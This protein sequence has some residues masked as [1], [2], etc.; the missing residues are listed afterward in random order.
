MKRIQ[1]YFVLIC[2]AALAS[3]VKTEVCVQPEE[4]AV[5]ILFSADAGQVQESGLNA[6]SKSIV[7]TP[8]GLNQPG[9]KLR[10]YDKHS[11][12]AN[13][14]MYIDGLDYVYGNSGWAVDPQ[15][16]WTKQGVHEFTVYNSHMTAS[17]YGGSATDPGRD[18]PNVDYDKATKSLKITRWQLSPD[19]QYDFM[20]AHA[21][22]DMAQPNPYAPVPLQMKHLLCAVQINITD[23]VTKQTV[24]G[25]KQTPTYRID[26]FSIKGFR[27]MATNVEIPFSEDPVITLESIPSTLFYEP[28]MKNIKLEYGKEH[29]VFAGDKYGADGCLLFFPH[30][31]EQ[32]ASVSATFTYTESRWVRQL[33]WWREETQKHT[34]TINFAEKGTANNWRAGYKYIY[35]FYIQENNITFDVSVVPWVIDDVILDE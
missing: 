6:S 25:N 20:Y 11:I 31:K 12:G 4:G 28:D 16:Y 21:T 27:D 29:N 26:N 17:T 10:V 34:I 19:N 33:F 7:S 15:K 3:C 8:D 14:S 2:L 23:L 32:F 1:S 13:S 5:P 24:D 18:A 30:Q 35:N 9:N 22:R